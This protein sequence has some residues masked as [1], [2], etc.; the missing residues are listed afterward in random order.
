VNSDQFRQERALVEKCF[1]YIQL[2]A[3]FDCFFLF[4]TLYFVF[5]GFCGLKRL[6]GFAGITNIQAK[7][8]S[9]AE[10]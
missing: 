9:Q 8:L 2:N 5:N 1:I 10:L 7:K 3:L 6:T 4:Q